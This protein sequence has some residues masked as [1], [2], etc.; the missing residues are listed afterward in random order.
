MSVGGSLIAEKLGLPLATVAVLPLVL[1]SR[2]LPP[3]GTRLLPAR[4]A[5]GRARDAVLRPLVGTVLRRVLDPI[6]TDV[7]AQVGLGRAAVS[8]LDGLF[9]TRLVLAQGVPGFDYPRPDLPPYVHYLG[10]LAPEPAP[11]TDAD[12]PPWWNEVAC[13]RV[14][15][16]PVV[17]VAQGT[18]HVDPDD[19]IR[20]TI[21][22][23]AGSDALVV[24]TT[25]RDAAGSLR[26]L[27]PNV[28]VAPFIPYHLLLPHVDVMVSNGG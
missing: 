17:H 15:G 23:L 25:G 18:L 12:L 13:A 22:A 4:T 28:R 27:P 6:I 26:S 20:P 16:R 5:A 11:G 14:E 1:T 10:R 19:L 9:S 7:R 3:P 2:H 21:A 24:A 8:G